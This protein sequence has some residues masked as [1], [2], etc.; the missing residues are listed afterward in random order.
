MIANTAIVSYVYDCY[1]CSGATPVAIV[2][3]AVCTLVNVHS[4]EYEYVRQVYRL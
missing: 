2:H 4:G 1:S 3:T